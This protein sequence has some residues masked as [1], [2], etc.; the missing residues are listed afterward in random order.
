MYFDP[1][2]HKRKKT[3]DSLMLSS[4]KQKR[5]MS[6]IAA[7]N[8]LSRLDSYMRG[9]GDR[10]LHSTTVNKQS[11]FRTSW[12]RHNGRSQQVMTCNLPRV[13]GEWL[14]YSTWKISQWYGFSSSDVSVLLFIMDTKPSE[15]CAE[16]SAARVNDY[17]VHTLPGYAIGAHMQLQSRWVSFVTT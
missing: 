11:D 8:W 7:Q 4:W 16:K 12:L 15:I 5:W 10:G 9:S 14:K 13:S 1:V 17:N 3:F 2:Q 6:V